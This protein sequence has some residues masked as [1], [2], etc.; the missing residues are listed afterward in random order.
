MA[1]FA[2]ILALVC[3]VR[4]FKGKLNGKSNSNINQKSS[5][6]RYYKWTP[7]KTKVSEREPEGSKR[8]QSDDDSDDDEITATESKTLVDEY[9]DSEDSEIECNSTYDT[10][11]KQIN[12]IAIELLV[13][14]VIASH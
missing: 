14:H 12:A 13:K 1:I 5:K 7:V 10:K 9:Q 6:R 4:R 3:F 2:G 11:K 8:D